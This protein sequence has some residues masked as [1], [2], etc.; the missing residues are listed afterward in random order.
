MSPVCV[1]WLTASHHN[2]IGSLHWFS[3]YASVFSYHFALFLLL[4]TARNGYQLLT[5]VLL[6]PGGQGK[7][8][9]AFDF[10]RTVAEEPKRF[11]MLVLSL[12]DEPV[13]PIYQVI[14]EI[15]VC[16]YLDRNQL[17][18]CYH[19]DVGGGTEVHQ[20]SSAHSPWAQCQGVPPV[21]VCG[22]WLLCPWDWTGIIM[23]NKVW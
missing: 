18:T 22:H 13:N 15:L 4:C 10:L 9:Q 1:L 14:T 23:C 16:V 7:V 5:S 8:L 20:H 2:T 11:Q 21:W 17:F 6:A 3:R 12:T 19:G